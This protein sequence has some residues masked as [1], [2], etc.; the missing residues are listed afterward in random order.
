MFDQYL[1]RWELTLDG[2]AFVSLNGHLLPVRYHGTPAMLK[3]S[4]EPEEQAGNRLMAWWDGQGAAP[5]LAHDGEALLMERASGVRSLMDMVN[6]G[7]DDEAIR[8]LCA[9]AGRLHTPR[10]QPAPALVPLLQRF[11]ALW[12]AA[13]THQGV[14]EQSAKAAREL[15]HAPRDVGVLHGD[16]HHAMYWTSALRGGSLSILRGSMVSAVLITRIFSAIQIAKAL[17]RQVV[18]RVG[19]RS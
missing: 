14:F 4:P 9:A 6:C 8:I 10:T 19:S 17:W 13:A 5:V 2:D 16:I 11:E 12:G 7:Q 1:K 18:L 3:I 15:L